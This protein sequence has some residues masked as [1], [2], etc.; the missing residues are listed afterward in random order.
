[1]AMTF[2]L[3]R[4]RL[5]ECDKGPCLVLREHIAVEMAKQWMEQNHDVKIRAALGS[6]VATLAPDRRMDYLQQRFNETG[7][8]PPEISAERI[9]E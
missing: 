8:L 9:L 4:I 2:R 6:Y 5:K 1:M 3:R 7:F